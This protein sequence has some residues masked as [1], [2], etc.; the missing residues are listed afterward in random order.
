[1]QDAAVDA[2]IAGPDCRQD[3]SREDEV[4]Q[5]MQVQRSHA[6][7]LVDTLPNDSHPKVQESANA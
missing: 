2:K 4:D 7:G 3:L 6:D 5:A 1:M